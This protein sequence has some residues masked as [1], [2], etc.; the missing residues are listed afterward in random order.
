MFSHNNLKWRP[1]QKD[2]STRFPRHFFHLA[3][4]RGDRHNVLRHQS[5][6]RPNFRRTFNLQ[7]GNECEIPGEPERTLFPNL[8]IETS[9]IY[10]GIPV[11]QR[12]QQNHQTKTPRVVLLGKIPKMVQPDDAI[13]TTAEMRKIRISLGY[14]FLGNFSKGIVTFSLIPTPSLFVLVQ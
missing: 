4:S 9:L 14:I 8:G 13:M 7:L 6:V 5:Q 2:A 12:T 10:D 1:I 3:D 11:R